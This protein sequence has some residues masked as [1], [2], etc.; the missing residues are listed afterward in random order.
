MYKT[1]KR[2][3]PSMYHNTRLLPYQRREIFRRWPQGEKVSNL[4]KQFLVSRPTI[5]KVLKEAKLNIFTNRSSINQRY[6][7]IYYGLRRLSKTEKIIAKK[8]SKKEKR[9]NRYEKTEPG[10]LVHFDTKRLPLL[11][12]EA[13][14]Q[15]R[16]YLHMAI[17]DYS[18]W[19]YADILPDKTSYSSAIHLEEVI[20]AMPFK[21]ESVYSDN[22]PE[23]KG[24][25]NNVFVKSCQRHRINQK[26]TKPH[27][28]YTN[29]KAERMIK[30]LMSEWHK[31]RHFISREQRRRFLYAYVNWY[32]QVRPHQS[33]NNQSP[34]QRLESYLARIKREQERLKS[35]NNP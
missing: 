23:Y 6:R 13:V 1:I 30:T 9:L 4:A 11:P 10:E 32:N 21:I 5:Y 17:D 29:G 25:K 27:H 24:N 8:I 22:G 3:S 18:R 15:P 2:P 19:A 35:V 7:T 31:Y 28:P 34:L 16:E 33:L 20:K 14:I 12:G 26:F